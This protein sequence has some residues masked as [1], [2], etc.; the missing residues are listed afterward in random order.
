MFYIG[1]NLHKIGVTSKISYVFISFRLY[2]LQFAG[3]FSVSPLRIQL[4]FLGID[5][6]LG[7]QGSVV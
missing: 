1:A 6:V 7:E 3:H 4:H 5:D 2:F